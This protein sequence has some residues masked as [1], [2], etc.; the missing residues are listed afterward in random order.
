MLPQEVEGAQEVL[1]S[2][3]CDGPRMIASRGRLTVGGVDAAWV[4][5]LDSR[6]QSRKPSSQVTVRTKKCRK[7]S[8]TKSIK[9]PSKADLTLHQYVGSVW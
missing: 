8:V 4:K 9:Q 7:T 3:A 2:N 6:E 1:A 5:A